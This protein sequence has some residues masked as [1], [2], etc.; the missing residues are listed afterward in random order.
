MTDIYDESRCRAACEHI[1][2]EIVRPLVQRHYRAAG[3]GIAHKADRSIVTDAD[4]AIEVKIREFLAGAFPSYG[5]LGEELGA[6]GSDNALVWTIDP[7]DGT[8]AFVAGVPL[9]GTLLAVVRQRDGERL[10]LLGAIYLPVQD[11]LA[12]GNRIE[13]TIDGVRVRMGDAASP[14]Q[15]RLILGDVSTIARKTPEAWNG[16]AEAARRFRSAQTWGDCLGYVNMLEGRAHARAEAGLGVDDVAPIEP[17][18][19]GAGGAVSTWDGR[20]LSEAL[21]ALDDI[22]DTSAS[23]TVAAAATG[24]LHRTLV[25]TLTPA[26]D[27]EQG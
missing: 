24:E 8:E 1:A 22:A 19:L 7:I 17:V 23:F 27:Y 10:P 2:R 14:D 16:V 21:S 18:V 11:R 15:R 4:A 20:T 9:F 3:L 26:R 13:T 6:V 12:I 25:E 5:V